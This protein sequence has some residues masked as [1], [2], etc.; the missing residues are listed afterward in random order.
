MKKANIFIAG[1]LL[2]GALSACNPLGEFK[3]YP[4]ARFETSAIDIEKEDEVKIPVVAYDAEGKTGTVTFK[5]TN[6]DGEAANYKVEPASGVLNFNGNETQNIVVKVVNHEKTKF[7]IELTSATGDFTIGGGR[8]FTV[9]MLKYFPVTWDYIEGV[10][11][12]QDFD[13]GKEDGT[14]YQV[15]FKKVDDTHVQLINLWGGGT[16]L[17][18]TIKFDQEANTA[19]MAFD[20]QQVVFDATAYGYGPLILIGMGKDGWDFVPAKAVASIKGITVG[21]WNILITEGQYKNY[22]YGTSYTTECSK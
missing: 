12:A 4:F 17:D 10:F 1:I 15:A 19:E 22:L 5:V 9:N 7:T 11:D 13:N 20:A 2:L 6:V 18:G 21:P 14:A 3:S 8:T 16:V